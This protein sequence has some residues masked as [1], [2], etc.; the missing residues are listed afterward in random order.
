MFLEAEGADLSQTTEFVMYY[1][2]PY[3]S[4]PVDHKSFKHLFSLEFVK[5]LKKKLELYIDENLTKIPHDLEPT[6]IKQHKFQIENK[7]MKAEVEN[8]HNEIL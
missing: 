3:I 4:N 7:N 6:L 2:L 8:L 1:A 5:E